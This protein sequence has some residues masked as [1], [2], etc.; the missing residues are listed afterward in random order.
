M[1]Y[2][3]KDFRFEAAHQLV[4]HD[5]KC[6]RMHGH[7]FRGTLIVAGPALKTTGPKTGMLIDYGDLSVAL[8]PI[9]EHNLDHHCLNQTLPVYPTSENIARWVYEALVVPLPALVGVTIEETCTARC[10]YFPEFDD[11]VVRLAE[12]AA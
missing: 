4:Q 1:Y 8:Q 12:E 6:A 9:L 2:L 11:E 10:T 5:G 7:S 3:H